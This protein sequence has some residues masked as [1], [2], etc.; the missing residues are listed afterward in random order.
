MS[1]EL[2][3]DPGDQ[4]VVGAAV[5]AAKSRLH[6][7]EHAGLLQLF[8]VTETLLSVHEWKEFA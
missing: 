5:F 4:A 8:G 1:A 3:T 7:P 2:E 6:V